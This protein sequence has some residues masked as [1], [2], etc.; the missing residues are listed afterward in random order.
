MI[1]YVES[2]LARERFRELPFFP[3]ATM[4]DDD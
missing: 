3:N 4:G 1:P 2:G